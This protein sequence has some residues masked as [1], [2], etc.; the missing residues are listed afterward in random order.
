MMCDK[1][2]KA[3]RQLAR[4]EQVGEQREARAGIAAWL[5]RQCQYKTCT[6]QHICK[7]MIQKRVSSG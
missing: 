2:K 7:S 1:C 5:H 3:G 6:C 4:S